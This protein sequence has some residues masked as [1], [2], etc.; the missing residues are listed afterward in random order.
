MDN[1][2]NGNAVTTT[3]ET[4][5]D[6]ILDFGSK[7][8]KIK[9]GERHFEITKVYV[10]RNCKTKY[11]IR[12]RVVVIYDIATTDDLGNEITVPLTQRY[13]AS[14]YAES[15]FAKTVYR[16]L[17][18]AVGKRFDVKDLVGIT[19]IAIISHNTTQAGDIFANIDCFVKVNQTEEML[20]AGSF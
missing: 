2:I 3:L 6:T 5:N 17:G 19:G 11:G 4:T 15:H 16:L 12:D 7:Q 14:D 18:R 8:P 13:L 1:L 9:A 10:E 20:L